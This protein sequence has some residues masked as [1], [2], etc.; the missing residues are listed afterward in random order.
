MVVF[1]NCLAENR[2]LPNLYLIGVALF[3]LDLI[4]AEALGV[5]VNKHSILEYAIE[6]Q[7]V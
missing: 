7:L 4:V 2:Y 5:A 1:S 3:D 6:Y